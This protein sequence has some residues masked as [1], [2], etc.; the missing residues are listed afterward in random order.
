MKESVIHLSG[1]LNKFLDEVDHERTRYDSAMDIAGVSLVR[2]V[3]NGA[4]PIIELVDLLPVYSL[5]LKAP[6]RLETSSTS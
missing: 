1:K 5:K 6:S 2:V 4:S 3:D